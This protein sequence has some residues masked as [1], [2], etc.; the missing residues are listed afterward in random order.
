MR[1][2]SAMRQSLQSGTID[3]YVAED[4]EYKSYKTVNP[5]IVAVN[6]NKMQGFKVDHDDSITSIGVKKGNTELLNQV[7]SILMVFLIKSA[8]N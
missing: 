2:F 1:S 6:L 3:G 8:T 7:N 5:N 4:I